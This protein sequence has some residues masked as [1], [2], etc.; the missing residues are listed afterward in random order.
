M[1]PLPLAR[2]HRLAVLSRIVAVALNAYREAVR[3]RI[4][5]GLLGLA[6]ATTAYSLVVGT[7]SLHQ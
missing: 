3:A 2:Y 1:T 7:L 5:Y 6:L 4:L